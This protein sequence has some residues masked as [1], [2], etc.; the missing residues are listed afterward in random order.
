MGLL[1][2]RG[3]GE[4]LA[5]VGD[6]E[7]M[8][9]MFLATGPDTGYEIAALRQ[10]FLA[11]QGHRTANK[12]TRL[13]PHGGPGW[14]VRWVVVERIVVLGCG[15][16][17]KTVV[18]NRLAD[19]LGLPV[20]HL[21]ALYYDSE[22]RPVDAEE[23]AARLRTAVQGPRW[24]LDGN[25][26]A[27]M[28]PRLRAA[29]TV[30]F[31]DLPGWVCLWSLIKRRMRYR[32]GQHPDGVFDRLTM[33]FARYVL[34]YRK[35]MAPRVRSLIAEHAKHANILVFTNRTQV[36]TWLNS[37]EPAPPGRPRPQT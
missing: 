13:F 1:D 35:S 3:L 17:G 20:A 26:A 24:I 19:R 31:L 33:G 23:F 30:V 18:A 8:A 6:H 7:A 22:W 5:A 36:T 28:P 15:G 10:E 9:L 34:A 16:S 12:G 29:D 2:H 21:D 32:G 14:A 25:Y 27:T 4:L 37:L 11:I